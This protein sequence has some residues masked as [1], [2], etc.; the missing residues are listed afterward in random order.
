ML[1]N[2]RPAEQDPRAARRGGRARRPRRAGQQ[3]RRRATRCRGPGRG[4]WTSYID[5][6][7]PAFERQR[8]SADSLDPARAES[9]ITLSPPPSTSSSSTK[10]AP[11]AF[12]ADLLSRPVTDFLSA[13]ETAQKRADAAPAD[14]RAGQGDEHDDFAWARGYE[15]AR[16]RGGDG[17]LS[18][19]RTRSGG[20]N[21]ASSSG[22]SL[23]LLGRAR[24]SSS[25]AHALHSRSQS[26]T[27][28]RPPP[29]D[30]A[31]RSRSAGCRLSRPS[32]RAPG[33]STR[34][35]QRRTTRRRS[36]RRPSGGSH[37]G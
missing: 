33:R 37:S 22:A 30:P 17:R 28:R 27:S 12:D 29:S 23:A 25:P 19:T 31:H 35:T 8:P 16:A 15:G 11:L 21:R 14:V 34:P 24:T 6:L 10:D 3:G 26:R 18:P 7:L 36:A 5:A 4:W 32:S 20:R 13:L 9:R 2:P 1:T